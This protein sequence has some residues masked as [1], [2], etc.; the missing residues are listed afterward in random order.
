MLTS[1]NQ[2]TC[3]NRLPIPT[4][5]MIRRP[6]YLGKGSEWLFISF[7]TRIASTAHEGNGEEVRCLLQHVFE[8]RDG[9]MQSD[10]QVVF[11]FGSP[12]FSFFNVLCTSIATQIQSPFRKKRK[13]LK[14]NLTR[15]HWYLNLL[16]WT[17]HSGFCTSSFIRKR[18]LFRR[19]FEG[20]ICI[21]MN[22]SL[23]LITQTT[24]LFERLVCLVCRAYTYI[25]TRLHKSPLKTIGL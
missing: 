8:P 3:V 7:T 23:Y 6:M 20:P 10:L 18:G 14:L 1:V 4:F 13:L 9:V 22:R 15:N 19:S 17:D 5:K 16:K 11:G 21:W 2:F 25:H 24:T 12:F